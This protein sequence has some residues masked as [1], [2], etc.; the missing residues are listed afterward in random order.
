MV[1]A[2]KFYKKRVLDGNTKI[3]NVYEMFL[4]VQRGYTEKLRTSIDQDIKLGLLPK[5][6]NPTFYTYLLFDGEQLSEILN[7]YSNLSTVA[8]ENEHFDRFC[9][10][11]FYPGKGL[12]CRKFQHAVEAKLLLFNHLES[13]KNCPRLNNIS[14]LLSNRKGISIVQLFSDSNHYEAHSREYA[15]IRSLGL[16]NI[17]NVVNGTPYGAMTSWSSTEILNYGKMWLYN[18][19]LMCI[20]EPPHVIT[21]DDIVL[22]E[23]RTRSSVKD[24]ELDGILQCFLEL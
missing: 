18:A 23:R 11:C 14:Q 20:I 8:V 9:D 24:W 13:Q 19:M 15:I 3:N 21:L 17:T 10:S 6:G 2:K 22:P 12:N 4:G 7:C 16:E 1:N 5:R